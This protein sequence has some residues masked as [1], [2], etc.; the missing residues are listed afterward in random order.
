MGEIVG[1][2][3]CT[4]RGA[5]LPPVPVLLPYDVEII[6]V[7]VRRAMRLPAADG[8]EVQIE[9]SRTVKDGISESLDRSKYRGEIT[10]TL[11]SS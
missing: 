6:E 8:Y 11:T 4:A 10:H 3:A 9:V 1:S 7:L 2:G 5:P